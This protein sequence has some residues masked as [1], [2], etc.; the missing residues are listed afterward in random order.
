MKTSKR[1]CQN[2]I[3]GFF[4]IEIIIAIALFTTFIGTFSYFFS[5]FSTKFHSSKEFSQK[6]RTAQNTF[7]T[8]LSGHTINPTANMSISVYQTGIKKISYTISKN[9]KIEVLINDQ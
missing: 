6:L 8:A 2:K 7:E 3:N 5:A 1:I 9:K 4:L